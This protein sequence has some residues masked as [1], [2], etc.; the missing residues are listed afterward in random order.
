[1]ASHSKH[2]KDETSNHQERSRKEEK[3][4]K[5]YKI[6]G[7]GFQRP[8]AVI[9]EVTMLGHKKGQS[10]LA[11]EDWESRVTTGHGSD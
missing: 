8:L 10:G 9:Q 6:R 11:A 1:V 7:N 4:N 3:E 5:K 2:T